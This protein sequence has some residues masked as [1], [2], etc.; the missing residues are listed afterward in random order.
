[1]KSSFK[2]DPFMAVT[3]KPLSDKVVAEQLE[4]EIKTASGIY[5]PDKAQEKPKLAR[6]VAVGEKVK[7]VKVGDQIIYE[8]Y[9]GT[10]VKLDGKEYVIVKEEKVLGIVTK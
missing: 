7:Q 9:S 3:I 2:E 10:N 6:V 1:M 5:L 4:A 8:E